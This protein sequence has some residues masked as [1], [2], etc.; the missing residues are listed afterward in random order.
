MG[1]ILGGVAAAATVAG[2]VANIAG[3][4]P[5]SSGVAQAAPVDPGPYFTE[6]LTPYTGPA[7]TA[8]NPLQGQPMA[9]WYTYGQRPEQTFFKNNSAGQ[10]MPPASATAPVAS[11][12]SGTTA[13]SSSP[14][15]GH[16][17]G[18]AIQARGPLSAV[19]PAGRPGGH[20]IQGP[21]DGQSDSIPSRLSDGEWV[22]DANFVSALGNGSNAAGSKVLYKMRDAVMR[23]KGM[24]DAVPPKLKKGAL[25][26]ASAAGA[27]ISRGAK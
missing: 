10:F 18:G 8:V 12:A 16:A 13:L 7:R 9:N 3:G 23:D 1:A 5:D 15:T 11:G 25:S 19:A 21:G 27:K 24:K 17:K 22:A 4:S 14:S 2:T 6:L 20:F 26:Y